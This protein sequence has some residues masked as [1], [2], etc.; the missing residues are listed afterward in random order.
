MRPLRG[1]PRLLAFAL[2]A[3][4]AFVALGFGG[5]GPT[6]ADAGPLRFNPDVDEYIVES[7]DTLWDISERVVGNPYLWPKVWSLNPE[8]TNPHWIFPGDIVRF[9]RSD[10]ELPTQ[11]L[12]AAEMSVPVD[13]IGGGEEEEEEEVE[14]APARIEMV[15]TAPELRVDRPV[16]RFVGVFVTPRELQEA[17]TLSNA[18]PDQIIL[19]PEARI[20]LTLNKGIQAARG[21]RMMLYRGLGP[22]EHPITEDRFG[23]MTEVTGIAIVEQIQGRVVQARIERTVVEVERGQLVTPMVRELNVVLQDNPAQ[24]EIKGTVV[25]VRENG[26]FA[27][28]GEFVFIDKGSKH[29]IERGNRLRVETAGDPMTEESLLLSEL[30]IAELQVLD[31]QENAATCMVVSGLEEVRPGQAVHTVIR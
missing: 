7:G 21:D 16:T 24:R 26:S 6:V 9:Y 2:G 22:V 31:V 17:G 4:L 10:N 27:G 18:S 13:E 25:A 3:G 8:I 5:R 14:D 30:R 11:T 29:G 1:S 28:E 15:D 12:I 19:G 23:Y 20:Y